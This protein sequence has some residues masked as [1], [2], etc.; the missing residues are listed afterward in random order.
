MSKL[1][2]PLKFGN[3][4]LVRFH[5]SYGQEFKKFRP[6][7]ILSSKINQ[8]DNRFTLIAP[9]T[10]DIETLNKHEIIVPKLPFL[11]KKSVIIAWY[12][13]TVDVNRLEL[14]LGTLPDGI[15][16]KLKEKLAKLIGHV[17]K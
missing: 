14:K 15:K 1:K 16:H 5:P 3:V 8:I 4:Y 6:A 10:S 7:V 2:E 9:L 13:R 12:M 11:N 17:Q